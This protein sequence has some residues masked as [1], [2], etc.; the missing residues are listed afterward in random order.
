MAVMIIDVLKLKEGKTVEEAVAYFESAKALFEG[1]GI[2]R[3]DAPLKVAKVA[4]GQAADLVNIFKTENPEVSMGGLMNDPEY[5][6]IVP[7]RDEIFDLENSTI[8]L[9]MPM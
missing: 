1:H 9:T 2:V 5:K 3:V 6:A 4:R 8:L 7:Q